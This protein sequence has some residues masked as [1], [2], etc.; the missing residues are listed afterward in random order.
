[1]GWEAAQ[2]LAF[3]LHA[4]ISEE[5]ISELNARRAQVNSMKS[6][7]VLAIRHFCPTHQFRNSSWLIRWRSSRIR[8]TR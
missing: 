2:S 1:M 5:R 4:L 8:A 3:F 6:S 7:I